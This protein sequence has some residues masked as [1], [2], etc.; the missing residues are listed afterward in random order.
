MKAMKLLRFFSGVAL[1]AVTGAWALVEAHISVARTVNRHNYARAGA[2]FEGSFARKRG[3][4][5]VM[6][7]AWERPEDLGGIDTR[8]AGVAF[9][10]RRVF[11]VGDDVVV[12]PRLQP[13]RVPE[14][15]SLVT[16]VR[17]EAQPARLGRDGAGPMG[18]TL[19]MRQRDALVKS[20]AAVAAEF[21][22]AAALQV[23]FDATISQREFYR[24]VLERLRRE[25]PAEMP[26]QVTAL[27]SWCLRDDWL[28]SVPIDDAIPMLFRMG[29][30]E[31][32]VRIRLD[33][34]EDFAS[35]ACRESLGISTDEPL[36]HLPNG[37]R[38]Y[39]FSPRAWTPRDA[40]QAIE[41]TRR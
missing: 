37:R 18:A 30:G 36:K 34:G 26:L 4:P 39:I 16:V 6:L 27:A 23:D 22:N 5:P 13:L 38:L 41:G 40:R 8:Q 3:L 9:L 21:P 33:A 29:M 2:Y 19:S 11:L 14:D 32:D 35:P 7:W 10:A 25:L 20:L 1:V 31:R 17:I 15:T 12:R 24:Q 28:D